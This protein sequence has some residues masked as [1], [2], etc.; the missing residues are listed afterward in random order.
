MKGCRPKPV[1]IVG[2]ARSGTTWLYH[3]LLSSGGFAIY[4]SE[5][6]FYNRFGPRFGNF[7]NELQRSTFLDSWLKSEFFLRS[8]LNAVSFREAVLSDVNSP[9]TMLNT[10]MNRI[11]DE[12][13]AKRWAECTPDYALHIRTIKRDFPD[14]LFIHVVRDGRDVAL[15]LAKQAF[16]R[17]FP[18]HIKQPQLASAAYWAWITDAVLKQVD[19]L[20]DDLLTVRYEDLLEN[21]DSALLRIATFIDKPMDPVRI[22]THSVGRVVKPNSSF[23][24]D[25]AGFGDQFVPRWQKYCNEDTLSAIENVIRRHL[26]RFGYQQ[27]TDPPRFVGRNRSSLLR[28]TYFVRFRTRCVLKQLAIFGRITPDGSQDAPISDDPQDPTTRPQEN[29]AI[30]RRLIGS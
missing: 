27:S 18:W 17:P 23:N 6:Q 7:A 30:I 14:A 10:F 5:T 16:I 2:C 19:Y 13:S 8:G 22:N 11:C 29:I 28:L 15:S 3:L 12:Q 4:R 24:R 9:G 1:F 26:D 21:L 25:T 20:G